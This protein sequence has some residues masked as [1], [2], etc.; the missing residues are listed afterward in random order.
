MKTSDLPANVRPVRD[1]HGKLRWRFRRSGWPSAYLEGEPGSPEFHAS[2]ARILQGG[3]KEVAGAAGVAKVNPRSLDDLF[4]RLKKSSRWR[5]KQARSQLVH[6][7]IIQ[8]LLDRRDGKGRRYGE[9]PVERVTVGWLENIFGQM[10]ETPA[11]ANVL[12]RNLSVLL[13][14]ACRMEWI[15]QNPVRLTE[16]Y[17][18]GEGWHDWTDA[19]IDQYRAAHP[20]GTMA[21]LTMELALNTAARRCNV[22]KIERD[23]IRDGLIY[24]AHAKDNHETAVEMLPGTK[25]ALDALPAAP[26]RFIVTT[27]FGKP[28][29]DAGLGNRMR[30]W[31]DAAGLPHCSLHGLRKAMSRILAEHGATD[32]EGQS[33]TGHK[34]DRTFAYYRDKANRKTLARHAM[35]KLNPD[36]S[37]LA[38]PALVQPEKDGD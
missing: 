32:A 10:W 9:R 3:P 28:F 1:R 37:N 26:I 7:R 11:A 35:A 29:S 27:Q 24:V 12:R 23:H 38:F 19:E 2:Y 36:L 13:D 22:N 5:S 34:K 18:E 20:L 31:C 15:G 4:I 21:R 25:A 30:K 33:V 16:K 6:G 14:L 17:Q 8:R